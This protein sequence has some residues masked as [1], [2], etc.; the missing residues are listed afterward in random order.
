M[1]LAA[2]AVGTVAAAAAAMVLPVD[3]LVASPAALFGTSHPELHHV[4]VAIA[5]LL[6]P[7]ATAIAR[8]QWPIRP[9][10]LHAIVVI[11]VMTTA[12]FTTITFFAMALALRASKNLAV[13]WG[14][15]WTLRKRERSGLSTE[16][17]YR[18]Q[19]ISCLTIGLLSLKF[20]VLRVTVILYAALWPVRKGDLVSTSDCLDAAAGLEGYSWEGGGYSTEANICMS[21]EDVLARSPPL[22]A[23][24]NLDRLAGLFQ[25]NRSVHPEGLG[26]GVIDLFG[27][28][29]DLTLVKGVKWPPTL[30]QYIDHMSIICDVPLLD[31]MDKH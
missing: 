20:W 25:S 3:V 2:V 12:S 27:H 16:Q 8:R 13:F 9:P 11:V 26:C 15:R 14:A 30:H 7:A 19:L 4:A 29:H 31:A 24:L 1:P 22:V 5:D 28:L 18:N 23:E 6:L 21:F 17:I 10:R